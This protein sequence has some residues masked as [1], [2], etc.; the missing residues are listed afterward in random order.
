MG[1]SSWLRSP[2][3]LVA[4]FALVTVV[5]AAVL[6][7]LGWQVIGLDRQLDS[8]RAQEQLEGTAD[9]VATE[10]AKNLDAVADSLP[11]WIDDPPA[12]LAAW[13]AKAAACGKPRGLQWSSYHPLGE[14]VFVR[15]GTRLLALVPVQVRFDPL[16]DGGFDDIPQAREPRNVIVLSELILPAPSYC[17]I[18]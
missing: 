15:D 5:P 1:I 8:Q 11:R 9:R 10:L 4:L 14:A 6:V 7:W 3:Y 12:S 18:S 13:F 16:P 2:R 17:Q